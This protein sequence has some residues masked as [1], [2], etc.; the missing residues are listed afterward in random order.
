MWLACMGCLFFVFLLSLNGP[1]F[2]FAPVPYRSGR[3]FAIVSSTLLPASRPFDMSRGMPALAAEMWRNTSSGVPWVDAWP[4]VVLFFWVAGALCGWLSILW[5]R[6][7]LLA[8]KLVSKPGARRYQSL[9]RSLSRRVGIRGTV[10][11]VESPQCK[12]PLTRGVVCPVIVLPTNIRS[13][14]AVKKRAVLLHELRHIKNRDSFSLTVAYAICSLFW[15]VPL[16]WAAYARLYLEQERSCDQAV[17]ESGVAP[18]VYATCILDAAQLSREPALPAGLSFSGRRRRVLKHRIASIINGGKFMKH[19]MILVGFAALML[20]VI[21]VMS[22]SG[23]DASGQGGK[24][25]GT[26]Y[27]KEYQP[28]TADEEA[29]LDTLVQYES[30]FN[31]HDL[32]KLLSLFAT[33]AVYRPCGV[34]VKYSIGSKDCQERIK[35]NFGFFKFETYYDPRI[36]FDGPRAV[37]KLLLETGDYLADYTFVLSRQGKAWL[38]SGA[39]YT[40]D[41]P[42]G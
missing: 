20:G 10:R 30:A 26:L 3:A 37:V 41:R 25:Y 6:L 24:K 2:L 8:M 38:V 27:L 15:F 5:G 19:G 36:L 9:I 18:H 34:D 11:V 28:K 14:S 22:A 40:N 4:I 42:K 35:Y 31:S 7:Q 32:Q 1:L 13:W 23:L 17:I 12:T 21:A 33:D 39:D 16:V 29:V